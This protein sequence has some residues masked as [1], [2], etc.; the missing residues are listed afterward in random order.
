MALAV[1]VPRDADHRGWLIV[2][3]LLTASPPASAL[4]LTTAEKA[5]RRSRAHEG[6]PT[7]RYLFP[8]QPFGILSYGETISIPLPISSPEPIS[9]E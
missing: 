3:E 6:D 8:S 1:G 9:I 7:V 5:L 4:L 2:I